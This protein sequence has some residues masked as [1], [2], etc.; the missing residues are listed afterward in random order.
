MEI[1]PYFDCETQS[2]KD[3]VIVNTIKWC[4][5]HFNANCLKHY[6]SIEKEDFYV[7]PYGFTTYCKQIGQTKCIYS[8]L[9]VENKYDRK[10]AN[11]KILK[12]ELAF[13]FTE[14]KF[15]EIVK[16]SIEYSDLK[17]A[18]SEEI[19]LLTSN[20]EALKEENENYKSY[21]FDTLHE[22][23]SLNSTLLA[24]SDNVLSI[25]KRF[26]DNEE[27]FFKHGIHSI[28][29]ISGLISSRLASLDI[30]VNSSVLETSILKNAS[31]YGKFF[32]CKQVLSTYFSTR[33]IYIDLL[34]ESF[35]DARINDL[36]EVCPY[37]IFENYLK[38]SPENTTIQVRIHED[39]NNIYIEIT[40]EGPFHDK[41]EL[42]HVF[43]MHYRSDNVK[44]YK[45]NGV[46]LYI[47][48]MIFDYLG[49]EI[50]VESLTQSTRNID[51]I[52][53]SQFITNITIPISVKNT[54]RPTP[55]ST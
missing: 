2:I 39:D 31:I 32:K 54:N 52:K 55:A 48:K 17:Y 4:K 19:R 5:K 15:K 11:P 9:L 13:K 14:D 27:D 29:A 46:G 1:I 42:K 24:H 47:V 10:K 51:N 23:R 22:I 8:S 49:F 21:V 45:G 25:S 40:N 53:Y 12:D 18:H 36:F 43:D 44:K 33:K 20:N 7:C 30:L 35:S 16:K 38:Y 3:G 37:L 50:S 26:L 28:L 41:H 6:N 34:G